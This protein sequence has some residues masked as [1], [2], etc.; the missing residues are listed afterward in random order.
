MKVFL[1]IT[2][3]YAFS[4][5]VNSQEK[6]VINHADSL[7]GRV[8]Q[9]EQIR[10]AI[11]NV[12]LSHNNIKINCNRVIQYINENRAELYGNVRLVS[13]TILIT[14]PS[15][16]YYG[17]EGKVVCPSGAV[18][19]DPSGVISSNYGVYYF[20]QDLASFRGNV[21]V[22]DERTYEII[23]DEINYYRAVQKSYASGNVKIITDSSVIY[24]D[25]L[26]Y[27]KLLGISSASG[28]VRI[29]SDS[30]VITSDKA[31]Y[32]DNENKSV[33]EGNV[34]ISFINKNAI[35]YGDYA[36][37]Y[38][39]TDYSF[40]KG[41]ARLIQINEDSGKED[42]TLIFANQMESF[43]RDEYY[44]AKD[45]VKAIKND[46]SAVSDIGYYLKNNE[47]GIIAI[48]GNPVVWKEQLQL[49]GD[50]IYSSFT[51]E[52]NDIFVIRSAFA[53]QPVDSMRYNQI[54]GLRMH[55]NFIDNK[56]N[57]IS[58]DTNSSA[59]YF[60]TDNDNNYDGANLV[61][62]ERIVM[63]F[64]DERITEVKVFGN[65][66]GIYYPEHLVNLEELRLIGF[67]IYRHRPLK[68]IFLF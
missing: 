47:A 60:I 51:D 9:G 45:S 68:N 12:S 19:R 33:A 16:I 35:V 8:I 13:D 6:I 49:S 34:K 62:G 26:I 44:R 1:F 28:N 20:I 66:D 32:Y 65:P 40:I 41:S 54:S 23:A 55:L 14:A 17:N 56:L 43:R 37:N 21:K 29:E 31:T 30:T 5:K 58:A 48:S 3:F 2:L 39:I 7:L 38:E 11:G 15:G 24:T 53:L 27:E 18:L 10:E 22:T 67:R 63:H 61:R 4:Y 42:T 25:N 57:K 64:N 59:I 50:S 36:E 46:F 52:L